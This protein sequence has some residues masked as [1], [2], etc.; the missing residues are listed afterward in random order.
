MN[1]RVADEHT[2]ARLGIGRAL[3]RYVVKGLLGVF[4][5]LSMAAS[6]RHQALHDM[7]TRSTVQIRDPS[8]AQPHHYVVEKPPDDGSRQP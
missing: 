1:L 4:S 2:D 6:R 5:F 7:M 8:K 3:G